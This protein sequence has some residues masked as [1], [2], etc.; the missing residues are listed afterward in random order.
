MSAKQRKYFGRARARVRTATRTVYRTAGRARRGVRRASRS[1][2]G[3]FMPLSV[4]DTVLDFGVGAL[5]PRV[6]TMA[7]GVVPSA[8]TS[9]AGSYED[10]VRLAMI[11]VAAHKL[12]SGIIKDAG[13]ETFRYAVMSAG[14]QAGQQFIGTGMSGS[15][16]DY[17]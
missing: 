1:T 12:G 16:G 7:A 9:W 4:R 11:G 13:R 17:L 3:G 5:A 15:S 10:E 6:N 8:L 14:Q 2:F